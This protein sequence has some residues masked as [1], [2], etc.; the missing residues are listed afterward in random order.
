MYIYISHLREAG[1]LLLQQRDH[2]CCT[3]APQPLG[4]RRHARGQLLRAVDAVFADQPVDPGLPWDL[5][6]GSTYIYIYIYIYMYIYIY[7]IYIHNFFNQPVD[8]SL[9]WNLVHSKEVSI[10]I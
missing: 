9:P 2:V 5:E 10:H 6:H 4:H 8:P 3:L 7:D 1:R